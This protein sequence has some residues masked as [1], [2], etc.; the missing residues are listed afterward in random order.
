MPPRKFVP[1]RRFFSLRWQAFAA[2][3]VTLTLCNAL[4]GLVAYRD[5]L[6]QFELQQS[7]R[8]GDNER[9][10]RSLLLGENSNLAGLLDLLPLLGSSQPDAAGLSPARAIGAVLDSEG[11]LLSLEWDVAAVH[12]IDPQGTPGLSWPKP[13]PA[14]LDAEVRKQ[15]LSSN[16]A[17]PSLQRTLH[18]HADC[19]QYVAAPLIWQGHRAGT[20]VLARALTT[21][22]LR[23]H[24]LTGSDAAVLQSHQS[25]PGAQH[26]PAITNAATVR[27]VL[28]SLLL[29][30][31]SRQASGQAPPVIAGELNGSRYEIYP[32]EGLGADVHAVIV[33][34]VSAAREVVRTA[35]RNGVLMGTFGLLFSGLILVLLANTPLQ[36]L[37]RI[38]SA[39]PL[40][41]DGRYRE[42]RKR[43]SRRA[44][45]L[46]LN[47]ELELLRRTTRSLAAR[48]HRI[49]RDRRATVQQ[50][51]WLGNHD[52]LTQLLNRQGFMS[53][54]QGMVE[55]AQRYHHEGALLLLDIDHFREINDLQGHQ[56][57]DQLL[58]TMATLL[59]RMLRP[60]DLL[61]RLGADEFVIGLPESSAAEALDCAQRLCA[62]IRDGGEARH[63]ERA[64]SVSIGITIFPANE[65]ATDEL[66][67]QADLALQQ[68][69]GIDHENIH[70]FSEEDALRGDFSERALWRQRINEALLEGHFQ[71]FFQPVVHIASGELH[72]FECL[73]RMRDPQ[74][75]IISPFQFIP[76]AEQTGQISDIDQWVLGA[77]VDR[78]A[79]TP[80]LRLSINLS[81][82]TLQRL[83]LMES[84][85]EL[86]EARAV[87]PERLILEVTETVAMQSLSDTSDIM[88]RIADRGCSFAL[89]DFGS[90]YA[91]Y[92]YLRQL[93]VREVKIDGT[94]VRNL[95]ESLDDRVFVKSITEMLRG[96]G[97]SVVAEFVETEAIYRLLAELGVELAQGYLLGR[98]QPEPT[99]TPNPA[100]IQPAHPSA[101]ARAAGTDD[102]MAQSG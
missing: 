2:L 46:Y 74:G 94:F 72:H 52:P 15:L 71:L 39:L 101:A 25:E 86:L 7:L 21:A 31:P 100:L 67:T 65:T 32:V 92:A 19:Y 70:L 35:A 64:V 88:R 48:M 76:I 51:D 56:Y 91:S 63:R 42:L 9:L 59:R 97:K 8:R 78:L 18:C 62:E 34:D 81:A 6:S 73:L 14:P 37:Q 28:E 20:L 77:A 99:Y 1:R 4:I 16:A 61:G 84:I 58:M 3:A 45:H 93:P 80:G 23:F 96:L 17:Q 47:D 57:G 54:L 75:G 95:E 49:E 29:S 24:A 89:D 50:L 38:V 12:W 41:A 55:H 44:G 82:R 60:S 40:L 79:A 90:G 98:P 102:S 26:Y 69:R 27:P 5:A 66:M 43:L 83:A 11:A 10:L 36:R 85:P 87:N 22:L 68:A 33:D 30:L 53:G 13:A